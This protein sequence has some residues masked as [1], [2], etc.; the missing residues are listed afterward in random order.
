METFLKLPDA[1]TWISLETFL[2]EWKLGQA[3]QLRPRSGALETFLVEWKRR[4]RVLCDH[5]AASLETFLVEWKPEGVA[6]VIIPSPALKP[7]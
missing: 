3:A 2:V 5:N 6:R 4:V 1:P 7:S